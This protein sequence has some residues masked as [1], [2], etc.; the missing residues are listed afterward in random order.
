MELWLPCREH[1]HQSMSAIMAMD[2]V[3]TNRSLSI[4]AVFVESI[5]LE[6]EAQ[7][8]NFRSI[9]LTLPQ[10]NHNLLT[11]MHPHFTI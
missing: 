10:E 7:V 8:S 1:L 4:M 5:E 3:E 2:L 6:W 11:K 9:I